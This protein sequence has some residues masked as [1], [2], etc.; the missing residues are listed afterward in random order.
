MC[1]RPPRDPAVGGGLAVVSLY[2]S[3]DTLRGAIECLGASDAQPTIADWLVFK[4]AL[5][6][7]RAAAAAGTPP[8][9]EV[10]TGLASESFQAAIRDA[11]GC[12]MPGAQ[13]VPR[14]PFFSP[15]AFARDSKANGF[16][17]AKYKSNGPSDTVAGWQSR[18]SVTP[19]RVV[20]GTKP[21]RYVFVARPPATLRTFFLVKSA[22]NA[23]A[24]LDVA[25]WWFRFDDLA[26]RFGHEPTGRELSDAFVADVDLQSDERSAIFAPLTALEEQAPAGTFQGTAADPAAYLPTANTPPVGA[27]SP[28]ATSA[29]PGAGG[30]D[31]KADHVCRFVEARGF[32]FDP[33]QIAAFITAVRTKP[34]VILAGISGTG[35]TK[36]PRLVAEATGAEIEVI[37]VRPDWT[38]G[39]EL[40]GYERITGAF[41]PGRLLRLAQRAMAAP[42]RQFFALL[43]EMNIARVE[44]YMADLLSHIEERDRRGGA[45]RSLP[46][47]PTAPDVGGVPWGATCLPSNL[48]IVGSVNMDETT[49]GFSRK[50]LDRS[51]VIEFSDIDLT[52]FGDSTET[53]TAAQWTAAEWEQKHL[54]LA[55][56]PDRKDGLI[57]DVIGALGAINDALTP[58]Q[59]QVGYRVRDEIALFCLNARDCRSSFTTPSGGDID[60]LDLA[61]TMKVLPRIQGGGAS[62]QGVIDRLRSWANP[63]APGARAFPLC[64]ERLALMHDRLRTGFTS[65]WL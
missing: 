65:Y 11:V 18:A 20:G 9:T 52:R 5:V 59:L 53:V 48:C 27:S 1:G 34:F 55:D 29:S 42:N 39:S 63:P 6:L 56:H 15:F 4:R 3:A 54:T 10:E 19:L 17:S 46:L 44:H 50:V 40:L 45:L 28:A 23:P 13:P 26:K 38:D 30:F 36:L 32:V 25:R 47:V 21:K 24:L 12:V 2:L 16:K 49:H 64:R 61:I 35:K 7:V 22:K 41:V 58:A 57:E 51:F 31:A 43:D 60:P 14:A 62:L 37:P 33:W 8:P